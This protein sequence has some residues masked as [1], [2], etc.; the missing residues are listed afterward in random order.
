MQYKLCQ[1]KIICL[2][3][4]I[5]RVT[6]FLPDKNNNRNH[7]SALWITGTHDQYE[8]FEYRRQK[9]FA[10]LWGT[11]IQNYWSIK[12]QMPHAEN[13]AVCIWLKLHKICSIPLVTR[14]LYDTKW[15][16]LDFHPKWRDPTIPPG[17]RRRLSS[18]ENRTPSSSQYSAISTEH[19]LKS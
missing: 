10:F 3:H 16:L 19:K 1:V 14:S 4:F 6:K 18:I 9:T 17:K 12:S 15:L 13:P 8:K 2:L 11:R 5:L 7:K